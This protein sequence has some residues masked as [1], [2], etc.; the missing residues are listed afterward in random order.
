MYR[1]GYKCCVNLQNIIIKQD[2]FLDRHFKMCAVVFPSVADYP[3][4]V[5]GCFSMK[6]RTYVYNL[7]HY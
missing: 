4:I 5:S 3:D 2:R 7:Q 1:I 6:T